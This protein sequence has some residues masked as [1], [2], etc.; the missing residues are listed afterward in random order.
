[1]DSN[2]DTYQG[3]CA[4]GHAHGNCCAAHTH[5]NSYF[6]AWRDPIAH[7]HTD[8]HAHTNTHPHGQACA[9]GVAHADRDSHSCADPV[10]SASS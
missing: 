2:C 3:G 8:G 6:E 4:D 9:Y 10:P 5:T 7:T 1:M